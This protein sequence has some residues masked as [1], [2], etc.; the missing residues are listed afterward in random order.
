MLPQ[1]WEENNSD[2]KIEPAKASTLYTLTY[3]LST[4]E[5]EHPTDEG[6]TFFH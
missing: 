5:P 3:T 2:K 1:K 6:G 4:E